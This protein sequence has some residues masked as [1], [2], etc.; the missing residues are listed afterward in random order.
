MGAGGTVG[1]DQRLR[2]G[3]HKGQ[4]TRPV[5]HPFGGWTDQ[6][7]AGYPV[8]RP[9]LLLALAGVAVRVP[10]REKIL[11]ILRSVRERKPRDA[12]ADAIR[13]RLSQ[14]RLILLDHAPK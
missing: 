12:V 2:L 4:A 10:I 8:R 1:C 9:R 7:R 11:A 5:C 14:W 13:E 6:R 3:R